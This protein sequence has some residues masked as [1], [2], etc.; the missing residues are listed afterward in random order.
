MSKEEI[1]KYLCLGLVPHLALIKNN[2]I[3]LEDFCIAKID[4]A[5]IKDCFPDINLNQNM[6]LGSG[7]NI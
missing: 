2:K 5:K 7:L 1:D 3:D 6:D 4:W